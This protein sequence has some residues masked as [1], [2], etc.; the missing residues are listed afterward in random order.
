MKKVIIGLTGPTGSGKSSVSVVAEKLGFKIINCDA[1]ARKATEKGT[2]GLKALCD[3]FGKDILN[4]DGTLNRGKL[5]KKAF[6]NTESTK[7]LN[8]TIL[9]YIVSLVKEEMDAERILLDA[10]TL[11]ESGIDSMCNATVA[12]LADTQ[13][14]L[15]R[16]IS[17]D[18]IDIQSGILRIN[19]GKGDDFYKENAD[20]I[21]Y[22]NTTPDDLNTQFEEIILNILK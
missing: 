15:K 12:V 14:R 3:A 10:P 19:A 21:I 4:T 1:L 22:N 7:L 13:T 17:R 6:K 11:F 9:P 8:S 2:Q 18:N 16:I 20:Y 5:A